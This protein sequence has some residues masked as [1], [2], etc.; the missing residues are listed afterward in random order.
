MSWHRV[1]AHGAGGYQGG[2]A[3]AFAMHYDQHARPAGASIPSL[4]FLKALVALD[5][6]RRPSLGI[7]VANDFVGVR[8]ARDRGGVPDL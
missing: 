6:G 1:A 4:A 7:L 3:A 8:L 2:I 5:I